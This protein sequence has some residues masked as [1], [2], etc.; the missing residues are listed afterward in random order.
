MNDSKNIPE[1]ERIRPDVFPVAVILE[2][3]PM[4]PGRWSV[5]Q[6]K[7][8]GI[9]A[10]E[11]FVQHEQSYRLIHSTED[12]IRQYMWTGFAVEL[13]KDSVESYWH[14]L[15]GAHPSLFVICREDP[16]TGLAPLRISADYDDANARMEADG[17]VLSTPIPPEMY[18]WLEQFVVEHYAPKEVKKRQRVDWIGEHKNHGP[19]T[20]PTR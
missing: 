19:K 12:G 5:P 14:N 13:F 1:G 4:D 7:V 17:T 6:W 15:V 16:D 8:V 11:H 9:V 18:L 10:G 3:R 20:L 2:S